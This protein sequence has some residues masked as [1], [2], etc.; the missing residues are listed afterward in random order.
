[1]SCHAAWGSFAPNQAIGLVWRGYCKT[2]CRGMSRRIDCTHFVQA[3]L[4]EQECPPV[5]YLTMLAAALFFPTAAHAGWLEDSW[6]DETTS[7]IGTPAITVHGDGTVA[8]V[9]QCEILSLNG[10]ESAV[11]AE[12]FLEHYG[13]KQ[14]SDLLVLIVAHQSLRIEVYLETSDGE[15]STTVQGEPL[16][17]TIDYVPSR[18]ISCVYPDVDLIS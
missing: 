8:V 9:L 17:L 6:S 11:A 18:R 3:D 13:P 1:V 10:V 15:Q 2:S 4:I 12:S 16:S 5:R 7:R 14:C